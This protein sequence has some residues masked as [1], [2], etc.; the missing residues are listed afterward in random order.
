MRENGEDGKNL[1][2]K[3]NKYKLRILCLFV[4]ILQK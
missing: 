2:R 1:K 4:E 3:E